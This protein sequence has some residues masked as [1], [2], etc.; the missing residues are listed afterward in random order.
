MAKRK[1]KKNIGASVAPERSK[2]GAPAEKTKNSAAGTSVN[3]AVRDKRK[4]K[5]D[6]KETARLKKENYAFSMSHSIRPDESVYGFQLITAAIFTAI[7]ILIVRQ[8]RYTRDMNSYY[9]SSDQ[10]ELTEFFS[11]YKVVAIVVAAIITI[12]FLLYRL[13]TQSLAIKRSVLY[14]PMGVYL[15]FVLLSFAFSDVKDVA[16]V[17][18]NDRFEGTAVLLCYM[19]MLFYIINS[20]NSERNIKWILYPVTGAT[21]LLSALGISQATD[22]DFFRTNFG[23]KLIVPNEQLTNGQ[24]TWEMIDKA[25]ETGERYLNFTFQ[26][27]EIYQTVYNINYVSFY[28]TLLLPIFGL[29]FIHEKHVVKKILWGVIFAML[30]FN[31]IGSSSSGGLLGSAV[32]VVVAIILLNKKLFQWWKSIAILVAITLVVGGITFDRWSSELTGTVRGVVGIEASEDSSGSDK[33]ADDAEGAD[34]AEAATSDGEQADANTED[35]AVEST[36]AGD[37]GHLIDYFITNDK[38]LTFSVDGNEATFSLLPGGSVSVTDSKGDV[39]PLTQDPS[40]GAILFEDERFQDVYF[41]PAQDEENNSYM[42]FALNGEDQQW[43]FLVEGEDQTTLTFKND[44]GKSVDLK[45]IPHLGFKNNPGFGS[46]RGYI[47]SASLPMIKD[48][49]FVGNGADTYCIYFPHNDYVGKYNTGGDNINIIVDKP[50]NMYIGI[51]INTG[52]LS[53][54]ALLALFGIYLVQSFRLY[55]RETFDTFASYAGAGIFLGIC[56]FLVA[57][58][59]NDST[60]SVMPMFYGL[61]GTGI[62]TNMIVQRRREATDGSDGI[63]DHRTS[64]LGAA[65]WRRISARLMREKKVADI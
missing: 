64:H 48:T 2:T 12:V 65:L 20:V 43:R 60:V 21:I 27:K 40:S 11:H 31:L 26:H 3:P 58:L 6:L 47:W 42:I 29:L 50:H 10:S 34:A 35:E 28:L 41:M 13:A 39:V 4:I 61:L 44:L 9:W 8:Y 57:G 15:V 54:L 33:P 18:W 1:R 25:A 63:K 5:E 30:I 46:G 52:L 22:H 37:S 14:I 49:I 62:A 56:G 32:I 16:W 38:G 51:A 36:K 45:Y 19:L 17:G 59:V 7:V 55:R 23:Q 53:L 24:T